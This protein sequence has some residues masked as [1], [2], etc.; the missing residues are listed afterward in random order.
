MLQVDPGHEFMG[1][2]TKEIENHKTYIRRGCTEIHRQQAIVE[3]FNRTF[4]ERLFGHQHAVEML[5]REGQRSTAWVKRLPEV[6]SALNNEVT[7]LIGKKPA[8][9]I[10][11]KAVASKPSTK[12]SRP[13]RY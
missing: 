7:S 12:Y 11:E 4:A 5:L 8:V 1:S 10:K 9:A 6:V 3:R 13:R 2:V